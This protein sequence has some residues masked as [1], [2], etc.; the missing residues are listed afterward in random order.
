MDDKSF[1]QQLAELESLVLRLEQG[2]VPLADALEA[3]EQGMALSKAC[4][5]RLDEAEKRIASATPK[6]DDSA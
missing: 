2:E 4:A 1:E 3:F 6:N 5:Q